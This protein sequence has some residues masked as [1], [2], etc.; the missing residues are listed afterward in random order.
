KNKNISKKNGL[1]Q[2]TYYH[3][4]SQRIASQKCFELYLIKYP[5]LSVLLIY[6]SRD[7]YKQNCLVEITDSFDKQE[8]V[9]NDIVHLPLNTLSKKFLAD[10][11]MKKKILDWDLEYAMTIHTSQGMMLEAL[12]QVWVID[13]HLSSETLAIANML[14]NNLGL[15][16]SINTSP[17]FEGRIQKKYIRE[18]TNKPSN[19]K[20]KKLVKKESDILEDLIKELS[21]KLAIQVL[22]IRKENA[23]S[24]NNLYNNITNSEMQ[25]EIMNQNIITNY[26]FFGKA[27]SE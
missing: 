13:E 19:K 14:D 4:L 11:L 12:Q 7:G 25:N 17:L 15:N 9:K 1:F 18:P 20:V 2:N 23:I 26:Y 10:I 24:F 3:H 21:T 16:L 27:L 6:Q 8:L 22:V 5:D